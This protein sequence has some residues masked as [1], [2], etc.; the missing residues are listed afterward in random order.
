MADLPPI[1]DAETLDRHRGDPGLR[2]V[3]VDAVADFEA[4]HIPRAVRVGYDEITHDEPPAGGLMPDAKTLSGVFSRVG[5]RPEDHIVV[6]DRS[7]GGAAGRLFFTLDVA[8][9]Q[10][11]SILDGGLQ[12]W[13]DID[14]DIETGAAEPEPSEYPVTLNADRIADHGYITAHLDDPHVKLL[15]VRSVPEYTGELVRAA[16]G[17]HIPGAANL[18]WTRLKDDRDRILPRD[19]ALRLLAEQ[20][21]RPEDEVT[22][23]CQTHRRSAHTYTVLKAL[24]FERVRG[25]PGSWSDWGNRTDTPV[26][27]PL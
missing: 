17:G 25:Y 24:G 3:A 7:G 4:E 10:G 1:I 26:E 13:L 9:H 23:Y 27:T 21:I 5:I 8:G 6:Y 2:I 19:E 16:R 11:L 12:A 15:D 18:E 20:G 22:V 14:G